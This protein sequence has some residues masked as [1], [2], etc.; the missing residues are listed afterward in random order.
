LQLPSLFLFIQWSYCVHSV[1]ATLYSMQPLQ[2]WWRRCTRSYLEA[3]STHCWRKR[4]SVTALAM[5]AM[6]LVTAWMPWPRNVDLLLPAGTSTRLDW[7]QCGFKWA[8]LIHNYLNLLCTYKYSYSHVF[9]LNNVD[10]LY[11]TSGHT[12]EHFQ[13]EVYHV[14][15]ILFWFSIIFLFYLVFETFVRH[16]LEKIMKRYGE[17]S[18]KIPMYSLLPD[19]TEDNILYPTRHIVQTDQLKLHFLCPVKGKYWYTSNLSSC[20]MWAVKLCKIYLLI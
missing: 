2:G 11:P 3:A 13:V 14:Q 5:Y 19:L 17:M 1:K 15:L 4:H 8:R 9:P 10:I 16:A 12:V 20:S 6:T 7:I 18:P